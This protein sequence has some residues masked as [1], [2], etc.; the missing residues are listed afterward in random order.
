NAAQILQNQ[1]EKDGVN[2][3]IRVMEWQAF[4]NTVVHPRN[5]VS[6]ILGWSMPLTPD[7]YPLWHSS[8]DILGGFNLPGYKNEKVDELIEKA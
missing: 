2:M 7:A 3:K 8:S 1:L 4:L 6:I 5:F